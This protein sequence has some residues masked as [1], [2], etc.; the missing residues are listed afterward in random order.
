MVRL[1]R[2]ALLT[3]MATAAIA[4]AA[5]GTAD[6]SLDG[7]E[8]VL[9]ALPDLEHPFPVDIDDQ[10][11][12]EAVGGLDFESLD[13]FTRAF[14]VQLDLEGLPLLNEEIV[15]WLQRSGVQHITVASRDEGLFVLVN[16]EMMPALEWD[17]ESVDNLVDVLG[18]FQRDGNGAYL[19]TP[20][21]YKIVADT[22]RGLRVLGL[23]V[24]LR[25]PR[26]E[27]ADAIPLPEEI[28]VD[29]MFAPEDAAEPMET[30]D[31]TVEYRPLAQDRGWVPSLFGLSTVDVNT[32]LNSANARPINRLRLRRDIE[33]RLK[34]KGIT[35]MA[36]E[37]RDDGVFMTV[38]DKLLPHL[39]WNES[40]LTN[41]SSLLQ[42]L[43]PDPEDIPAAASWVP[44]VRAT[45]PMY[46]DF[47]IAIRVAFPN[48]S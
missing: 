36:V 30:V 47:A 34:A 13:R 42:Q 20:D 33:A 6:R 12:I 18:E 10:G 21:D 41:V 35:S 39:K 25:L 29:E 45:A 3:T 48:G 11:R 38:N 46:N 15:D 14:G 44:V 1:A 24:D 26:P 22:L 31:V 17:K 43:Y 27:G 8:G 23:R 9:R 7:A 40:S 37:S 32:I 28:N 4:V 19:L 2:V 5:C 16:G